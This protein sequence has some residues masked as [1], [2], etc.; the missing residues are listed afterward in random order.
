[1]R[2]LQERRHSMRWLYRW[3]RSGGSAGWLMLC[4][5]LLVSAGC[6][7]GSSIVPSGGGSTG[8]PSGTSVRG[9]VVD[10]VSRQP[11]EKATVKVGNS[12]TQTGADGKFSLPASAGT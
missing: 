2:L 10:S 12:S 1:M 4:A 7:G 9:R 3:K 6:G 8:T 5:L 11:I